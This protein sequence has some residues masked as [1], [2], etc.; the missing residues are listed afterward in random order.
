MLLSQDGSTT[1][2]RGTE[3]RSLH[4]CDHVF[5][6]LRFW[7]LHLCGVFDSRRPRYR[8]SST[9]GK[10]GLIINTAKSTRLN[11]MLFGAKN[12]CG[13]AFSKECSGSF[14]SRIIPYT[15][16]NSIL[17]NYRVLSIADLL[18]NDVN[19]RSALWHIY[20]HPIPRKLFNLSLRY[21]QRRFANQPPLH[22]AIPQD[23]SVTFSCLS[24]NLTTTIQPFTVYNISFKLKYFLKPATTLNFC[25]FL[26]DARVAHTLP[27][28]HCATAVVSIARCQWPACHMLNAINLRPNGRC[29]RGGFRSPCVDRHFSTFTCTTNLL[30]RLQV[31]FGA[32]KR[33]STSHH[34]ALR[35]PVVRNLFTISLATFRQPSFQAG[36]GESPWW[37]APQRK[38]R[39]TSIRL[40]LLPFASYLV[41]K[42]GR[43]CTIN[44]PF[45]R[46]TLKFRAHHGGRLVAR[47]MFLPISN[48][49]GMRRV[50]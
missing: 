3:A 9:K 49:R 34:R 47:D 29:F 27:L 1:S 32:R 45:V 12:R 4:L 23:L 44:L 5:T 50:E 30:K 21:P 16:A 14:I 17:F 13:R 2:P 48:M 43:P 18:S 33:Y 8:I 40:S 6:G 24:V 15:I 19:L 10:W 25:T 28:H 39:R 22:S 36:R 7:A 38:L 20:C 26:R 31:R 35:R 11:V 42:S 46:R 37:R 41:R